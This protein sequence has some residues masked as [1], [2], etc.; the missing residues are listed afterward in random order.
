[1]NE[2]LNNFVQKQLQLGTP[3]DQIRQ[4][5]IDNEW[6]ATMVDEALN[7]LATATPELPQTEETPVVKKSQSPRLIPQQK[8]SP[9]GMV[10]G[11][12]AAAVLLI[13]GGAWGYMTYFAQPSAEELLMQAQK[14][15]LMLES[16]ESQMKIDIDVDIPEEYLT[17][18]R[19]FVPIKSGKFSVVFDSKNAENDTH[20]KFQLLNEATPLLGLEY[21]TLGIDN[22]YA[23]LNELNVPLLA[24][25]VDMSAFMNQWIHLDLKE[26]SEFAD[27]SITNEYE[28]II[29]ELEKEDSKILK[30]LEMIALEKPIISITEDLGTEEMN[31]IDTRHIVTKINKENLLTTVEKMM[32]L[33]AT[34]FNEDSLTEA[35]IKETAAELAT[36]LRNGIGNVTLPDIDLWIGEDDAQLYQAKAAINIVDLGVPELKEMFSASDRVTFTSTITNHNK[37]F[38]I[39]EPK[40]AMTIEELMTSLEALGAAEMLGLGA[41]ED[42]EELDFEATELTED[43][44]FD[45]TVEVGDESTTVEVFND[46]DSDNDGLSDFDEAFYGTEPNN[47]DTDGDGYL[48]G[49]EVKAGY[50]PTGPGKLNQ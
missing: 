34:E 8:N 37:K 6:E 2:E 28:D 38:S 46:G 10:I 31:G 49:D 24:M 4:M 50:S 30:E 47:P 35:E 23:Q 43:G 48:D 45:F 22:M 17:E 13:A 3:R 9:T 36:D 40:D 14:N 18:V 15:T 21:M 5:L 32:I 12:I 41:E 20:T 25:F 42:F 1:M 19:E 44:E 11:G 27:V 33:A 39:K 29:A 7:S 26:I 16:F